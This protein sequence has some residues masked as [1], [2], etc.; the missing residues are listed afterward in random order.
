MNSEE[1]FVADSEA[2]LKL[3]H[4]IDNCI[5]VEAK[6]YRGIVKDNCDKI[7]C[8][9]FG[10]MDEISA[11]DEN[12]ANIFNDNFPS[13]N[14]ITFEAQEGCL[15]RLFKHN[16]KW[17]LSTHKKLNAF[18]SYW[19][20]KTSFGELFTIA[21]YSLIGENELSLEECFDNFCKTLDEKYT[22]CFLLRN[23]WENRVVCHSS[24]KPELIYVGRFEL[25]KFESSLVYNIDERFPTIKEHKFENVE[26]LQNYV[27]NINPFELQGLIVLQ[28]EDDQKTI[29][30]GAKIMNPQ[31]IQLSQLRGNVA[32]LRF[33]YLE[34]RQLYFSQKILS[35][36][37]FIALYPEHVAIFHAIDSSLLL[38][39]K[40]LY[41]LYKA[42]YIY[43]NNIRLNSGAYYI[44]KK[45]HA[46]YLENGRNIP[47][48]L[49]IVINQ[50]NLAKPTT[51]NYLLK[52]A[53]VKQK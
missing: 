1:I 20:S 4:F 44:L 5:D 42:R 53:I 37:Y 49:D 18:N 50:I 10:Q 52:N 22:W 6:K 43:K 46:W 8:Q 25:D 38:L 15:L 14:W 24:D 41:E 47:V 30:F 27:C 26:Q 35:W 34:L 33:R 36:Q 28:F 31:Y 19:S 39:S 16:E 9:S 48:S 21:L 17:Y 51:L 45:C 7:V 11:G 12:V 2:E 3:Y 40:E 29:K 23:T 32:S 13:P